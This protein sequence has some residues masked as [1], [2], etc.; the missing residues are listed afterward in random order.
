[1]AY[2]CDLHIH[3]KYSRAT[4]KDMDV[5]NL[6]RWASVKGI[7][8]LGTGDFTHP[9][10]LDELKNK[11][12]PQRRGIYEYKGTDFILSAEVSNIY[13]KNGRTRKVHNVLFAPSFEV[14]GEIN[15]MLSSYGNLESD[16]RPILSLECD[17][18]VRALKK[19][20]PEIMVVP[21]HIWTPHFSVYGSNSGF[22][23]M[24]ECF[25]DEI[26][27][28]S[29]LETGLSS[30]PPMNW[31]LST[32]D[33]YFLVSNSDAHSPARIGRE[34]NVLREEVDYFGLKEALEKK[35]AGMFMYTVEFFPQEGKYHW[36]GHRK[37]GARLSPRESAKINNRC[38]VC[39]KRL[40]VGVMNR[41]EQLADRE[42][43]YVLKEAPGFK[44]MI[45]LVEIISEALGVGRDSAAVAREYNMLTQR[46]GTE[47]DILLF[48]GADELAERCPQKITRGI[49][50]VREGRVQ[51]TPGYDGEYGSV[52]IFG[53]SDEEKEKQLT[54]F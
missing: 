1:M 34:A 50:N 11:L 31:R 20:A 54:F 22:D 3:S 23:T 53:E 48:K 14:V 52:E 12:G 30:D 43:G 15:K 28:L 26:D 24:E 18:M 47:F 4:S 37:C 10:W 49:L 29:A 32:L 51:V 13:F 44:S 41:V 39:G 25:E 16:G 46:I 40:T 38:P 5:E 42:E 7:G 6:S 21:A 9:G 2:I 19:I 8:L 35:D 27:S 45:P 36:D 17:K 33:R